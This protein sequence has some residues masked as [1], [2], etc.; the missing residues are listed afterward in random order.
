MGLFDSI[1]G[2]ALIGG[3]LGLIGGRETDQQNLKIANQNIAY[4]KE[5]AKSGIQWRTEDAQAAGIHPLF[6]MG[7]QT[8]SFQNQAP[9]GSSAGDAL[10]MTGRQYT[11]ANTDLVLANVE[12]AKAKTA[13]I[14]SN[15][16]QDVIYPGIQPVVKPG[17]NPNVQELEKGR[18]QPYVKKNPEQNLTKISPVSTFRL[19][20]QEVKLPIEDAEQITE[21]P[22]AVAFLAYNYHGNKNV[23]WQKVIEEYTGK[24]FGHGLSKR[25]PSAMRAGGTV[26]RFIDQ[27]KKL[28]RKE[29]VNRTFFR[30][31]PRQRRGF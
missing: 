11:R 21:D 16:S 7:A 24:K 1:G 28:N 3:A 6:A 18:V 26:R 31:K 23:N 10:G 8:S 13:A 5:F 14:N 30:K 9:T 2:G 20:S 4:Q 25:N 19:G 15:S 12:L 22:A 17:L 27:I 29:R